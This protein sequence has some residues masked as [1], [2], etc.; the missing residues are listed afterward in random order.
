MGTVT[1]L[2]TAAEAVTLGKAAAAFLAT[3][4]PEGGNTRLA[5]GKI[6]RRVVAEFGADADPAGLDP[7]VFA[8]WFTGQWKDR[9][10][11]TWNAALDAIRSAE[12]Y[13]REQGWITAAPSR[14]LARRRLP[15][16]RSR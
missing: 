11:A 10:P 1:R 3:L 6:L 2:S 15:A 12:G 14:R 7:D 8:T 16:E 4:L 9:R 13:W 5:Y